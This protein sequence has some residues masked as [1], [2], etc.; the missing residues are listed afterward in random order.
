L[1]AGHKSCDEAGLA[2]IEIVRGV[3][4][5]MLS[6]P[7]SVIV[8]PV[9]IRAAIAAIASVRTIVRFAEAILGGVSL[10][11]TARC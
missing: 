11:A 4:A 1:P 3:M 7:I 6:H 8:I 5:P 2:I 10:G 9:A